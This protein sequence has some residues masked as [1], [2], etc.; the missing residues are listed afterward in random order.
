MFK[1]CFM[2]SKVSANARETAIF[3]NNDIGA[4]EDT[5]CLYLRFDSLL[6]CYKSKL[7]IDMVTSVFSFGWIIFLKDKIEKFKTLLSLPLANHFC[8]VQNVHTKLCLKAFLLSLSLKE[9]YP[10][11]FQPCSDKPLMRTKLCLDLWCGAG[12]H[13]EDGTQS[14]Q[15]YQP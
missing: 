14:D 1:Y 13:Q 15:K 7:L 6:C 5:K 2:S 4:D 3:L 11:T 12:Q 8:V 10:Y 9:N